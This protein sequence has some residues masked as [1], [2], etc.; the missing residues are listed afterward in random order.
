MRGGGLPSLIRQMDPLTQTDSKSERSQ[1][2]RSIP[3][4]NRDNAEYRGW[5]DALP[6]PSQLFLPISNFTEIE[7]AACGDKA[8]IHEAKG[9]F[10]M[11]EMA[12][13]VALFLF[14]FSLH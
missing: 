10:N 14:S 2:H 1:V 12:A 4:Q 8:V 9:I 7:M 13:K 5:V 3:T 11:L 6:G